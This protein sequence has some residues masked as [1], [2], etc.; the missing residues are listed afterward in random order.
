LDKEDGVPPLTKLASTFWKANQPA[1]APTTTQ[2]NEPGRRSPRLTGSVRRLPAP[3]ND[4]HLLLLCT[5]LSELYELLV[6]LEDLVTDSLKIGSLI[7]MYD[8]FAT[9][10]KIE[11]PETG[12]VHLHLQT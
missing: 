9:M 2:K 5:R 11:N 6:G 1:S 8:D 3:T 4:R 7:K 10:V 12:C